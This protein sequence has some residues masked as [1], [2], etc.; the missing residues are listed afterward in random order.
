MS[1]YIPARD[2]AERRERLHHE[3]RSLHRPMHAWQWSCRC[4]YQ[5]HPTDR[6]AADARCRRDL[7]ALRQQGHVRQLDDGRWEAVG[8]THA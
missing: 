6:E 2:V 8:G 4:F 1:V 5:R 3:M 7:N